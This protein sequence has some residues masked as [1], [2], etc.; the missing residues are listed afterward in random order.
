MMNLPYEY[1]VYW[2]KLAS[3][4]AAA[5][6]DGG[7]Q[8]AG[9]LNIY[10]SGGN[11]LVGRAYQGKPQRE[12][13]QN[14]LSR[15][16]RLDCFCHGVGAHV[17]RYGLTHKLSVSVIALVVRLVSREQLTLCHRRR[18]RHTRRQ[19]KRCKRYHTLRADALNN[20]PQCRGSM[21][22]TPLKDVPNVDE[23]CRLWRGADRKG[24]RES[25]CVFLRESNVRCA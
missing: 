23:S 7:Q 10:A 4:D 5:V 2:P 1:L 25:V 24:R 12:C 6:V 13:R 19:A 9:P 22:V 15:W 11:R 16:K 21:W 3:V 18:A 8:K 17:F 20:N 14:C